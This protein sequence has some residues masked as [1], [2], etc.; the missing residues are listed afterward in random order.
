MKKIMFAIVAVCFVLSC[1]FIVAPASAEDKIL[2]AKIDSVAMAKDKNGNAYTRVIVLE[3]KSLQ[4]VEYESG[5]P[6]MAFGGVAA[7]AA[8]LKAGGTL[9]AIVSEREYQGRNSY[10][11]LS[12]LQ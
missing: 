12:I 6:A 3:K 8:T 1:L 7:K 9:K 11:I 4:G 2:T 5:V 10:T